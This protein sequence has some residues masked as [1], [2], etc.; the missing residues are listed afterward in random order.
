MRFASI[1]MTDIGLKRKKNEDSM[2][3]DPE[4]LIF[5]VADGMGGHAAGEHASETAVETISDFIRQ[6]RM[7]T[8]ITWPGVVDETRSFME[9]TLRSAFLLAHKRILDITQV[10]QEWL[11]MAT[12]LVCTIIDPLKNMA[13][14]AHV[15]DSRA[16]LVRN[17]RIIQLTQDHS[18]VNEQI[19]AGLITQEEARNHRLRNVVTRALGGPQEP[20][21]DIDEEPFQ[22][23]DLFMLCT[24]GLTGPVEDA[25]ILDIILKHP[26]NLEKAA[27]DLIEKAK[28][29]GGPDNITLIL[30]QCLPDA[31]E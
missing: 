31:D 27:R 17:Q 19:K 3:V 22:P 11:G 4:N 21:V 30:I 7:D 16:Y 8:D 15:G 26:D 28:E 2:L 20:T 14:I 1:G 18:W 29:R 6:A 10:N 13:F 9:N 24:D 5:I 25:E 12:T 23:G